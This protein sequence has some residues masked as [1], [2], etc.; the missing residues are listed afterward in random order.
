MKKKLAIMA[1]AACVA[2]ASVAGASQS[3]DAAPKLKLASEI[4]EEES[5]EEEAADETDSEEA[6]TDAE[7]TEAE[8]EAAEDAE[9]DA[10][11]EA[12]EEEGQADTETDE[13]DAQEAEDASGEEEAAAEEG[14]ESE[15]D[16]GEEAGDEP[17]SEEAADESGEEESAEGTSEGETEED[18]PEEDISGDEKEDDTVSVGVA[19]GATV[20]VS[21]TGSAAVTPDGAVLYVGV[22]TS[23][24]SSKEAQEENSG[25]INAVIEALLGAGVEEKDI[26]TSSFDIY[27]D[28]DYVDGSSVFA[29]YRVS[30]MLTVSNLD[31]SAVGDL[32]DLAVEAGANDIDG[33]EYTY[34]DTEE[35]YDQALEAAIDRAYAKA[36]LIA[37][38]TGASLEVVS[39]EEEDYSYGAIDARSYSVTTLESA[40][41]ESA[42]MTVLAGETEITA[43]VNVVFQLVEEEEETTPEEVTTEDGT[44]AESMQQG[45]DATQSGGGDP[46]R[47]GGGQSGDGRDPGADGAP[48]ADIEEEYRDAPG[49]EPQEEGAETDDGEEDADGKEQEDTSDEEETADIEE[50]ARTKESEEQEGTEASEDGD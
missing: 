40:D 20:A 34:S 22:E 1:I 29:G 28:Y 10:E 26:T 24:E 17:M 43:T 32:I 44:V 31:I 45:G 11:E 35:A 23:A 13:A 4:E 47:S 16:A 39:I 19:K 14:A 41:E 21:G 30:T 6:E 27:A 48:D 7:E 8:E 38:K 37:G 15:E 18:A 42:S 2:T 50:T 46:R 49:A 36:E 5:E 25:S 33:I 12:V 9:E 3:V